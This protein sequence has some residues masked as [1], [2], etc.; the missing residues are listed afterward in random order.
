M[1]S[2]QPN[3]GCAESQSTR[4]QGLASSFPQT[5]PTRRLRPDSIVI[6]H[7]R[8]EALRIASPIVFG[9]VLPPTCIT[10]TEEAV[11]YVPETRYLLVADHGHGSR[12][13]PCSAGIVLGASVKLDVDAH[14]NPGGIIDA[15]S[16]NN[17]PA[18]Q[19]G[20]ETQSQPRPLRKRHFH[21]SLTT[22]R[23]IARRSGGEAHTKQQKIGVRS[24]PGNI[25]DLSPTPR[26][27]IS[28][29][30]REPSAAAFVAETGVLVSHRSSTM[31]HREFNLCA[32]CGSA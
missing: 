14:G 12:D 9:R 8:G 30:V 28:T 29:F 5:R 22:G 15:Q 25:F 11:T 24:P 4:P 21:Q 6:P 2:T 7:P 26:L 18:P 31:R 23:P 10:P 19:A 32:L 13:R 16:S 20:R 3:C 27:P 17:Y 1:K